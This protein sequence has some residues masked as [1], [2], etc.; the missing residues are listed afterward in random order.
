MFLKVKAISKKAFSMVTNVEVH[1]GMGCWGVRPG[2]SVH[3]Q[4]RAPGHR[5]PSSCM[6][7]VMTI[8]GEN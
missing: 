7:V 8:I 3:T 6:T 5:R 2:L 1:S 4:G